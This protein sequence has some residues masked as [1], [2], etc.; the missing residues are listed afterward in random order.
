MHR[1]S[2][3]FN[4]LRGM[5]ALAAVV[6]PIVFILDWRKSEAGVHWPL[7]LSALFSV[8]YLLVQGAL[9]WQLKHSAL[10]ASAPLPGYFKQLFNSFK[11]SNLVLFGAVALGFIVEIARSGWSAQLAWPLGIF[12]F[13]VLEH[14]NYYHYQLMY[15]TSASVRYVLRNRRL[16]KAALGIDLSRRAGRSV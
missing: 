15:D 10:S 5:E 8:S 14:I 11:V 7:G 12:L 16:R 6:L 3:R 4:Y 1:L 2:S 9:Y 13:A